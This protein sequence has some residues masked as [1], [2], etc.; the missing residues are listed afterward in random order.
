MR[1]WTIK[2]LALLLAVGVFLAAVIVLGRLALE[3]LR[4]QDRY[5]L[6]FGDITCT[7]PPGLSREDFLDEVQYLASFGPRLHLLDRDLAQQLAQAFAR[8]PWVAQVEQVE[9]V[10]PGQVRVRLRYRRPV[11]AVAAGGQ[12]RVVDEQGILLPRA[13]SSTGLPLFPG[14]AP[15]PAGPAGSRWGDPAV[16]TAAQAAARP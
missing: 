15:P 6:P 10:P 8:H 11:L 2:S 13:A 5:T 14:K 4:A 16:E 3:N 7:P 9:V 12:V 1:K